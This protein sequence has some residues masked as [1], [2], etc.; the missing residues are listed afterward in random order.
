VSVIWHDLECGGY[1]ADLAFWRSLASA[2]GGPV[3]DIGAGT[4]RVTLDLARTGVEVTALDNDPDL[5]VELRR[6][7]VGL[8]VVTVCADARAFS[9]PGR[10]ALCVMPMQ[11]L[12]LLGGS[13]GRA[14]FWRCVRRHLAPGGLLAAAIAGEL[15][16]FDVATGA[17]AP[18]PDVCECEG[19]VYSS[20]PT[21]VRADAGG[22][23]LE[24]DREIVERDG[25]LTR[26]RDRIRLDDV[27]A[28]QL[29]AEAQAAGLNKVGRAEIAPT[30]DHVGSQ[31]VMFGG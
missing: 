13:R 25:T 28:D 18:L 10:F 7:A 15:D 17:L 12:Q 22:F 27:N 5:L 11:T 31:V 21:A 2:R 3:L 4:G 30:D 8:P 23:V 19:V 9:L 14:R 29:E 1:T 20:L 26:A 6:R 16:P 24:R